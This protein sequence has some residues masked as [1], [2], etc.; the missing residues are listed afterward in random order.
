MCCARRAQTELPVLR[1]QDKEGGGI[2]N[3]N[4]VK[5]NV[6]CPCNEIVLKQQVSPPPS[7]PAYPSP[8]AIFLSSPLFQSP[9]FPS[10]RPP[11]PFHALSIVVV[12]LHVNAFDFD[13]RASDALDAGRLA[14]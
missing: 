11:P 7:P 6:V 8:L 2:E 13:F 3:S 9:S 14:A 12:L 1:K 10:S 4:M 5:A